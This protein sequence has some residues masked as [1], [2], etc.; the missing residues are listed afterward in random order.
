[1]VRQRG[2]RAWIYI[3]PMEGNQIEKESD[4]EKNNS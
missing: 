2:E 4:R 1:M 3:S